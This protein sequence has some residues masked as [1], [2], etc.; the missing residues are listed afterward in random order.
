MAVE[1][2]MGAKLETETAVTLGRGEAAPGLF[3]PN[4]SALGFKGPFCAAQAASPTA[5]PTRQAHLR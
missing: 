2:S 3:K 5:P 4:K 1:V